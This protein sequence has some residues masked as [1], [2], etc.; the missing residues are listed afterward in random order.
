MSISPPPEV[1][2]EVLGN[3]TRRKPHTR[4]S[5]RREASASGVA[6]FDSMGMRIKK[7]ISQTQNSALPN[8][9]LKSIEL[10]AGAGG[11]AL[12]VSQAGFA[13]QAVIEMDGDC[14]STMRANKNGSSSLTANWPVLKRNVCKLSY[15]PFGTDLD[16]LAG[17][18]PCQP[19]SQGGKGGGHR[20]TRNMFPQAVRA[21]RELRPKTFVFENVN[22]L[23]RWAFTQYV[24][25]L[26]LC[27]AYPDLLQSSKET[28]LG[29]H[30]RLERHHTSG[31]SESYRIVIRS[32]NAANYGVPQSRERVIIVG[33]RSDLG[34]D[35]QFPTPSHS[36]AQLLGDQWIT[37]TYWD[38]HAIPKKNRPLVPRELRDTIQR[39]RDYDSPGEPWQ[40][41][42]DAIGDLS[43]PMETSRDQAAV[44]NHLHIPGAKR[45]AG[46]TG[47][48]FDWPAKALKAGDH[49]VPGGENMLAHAN[50]RVRYFTVRECARLQTFPDAY[51]F[52]G[53]WRST[54]RQLGNAVPVR[55][56]RIVASS[57]ERALMAKHSRR[58]SPRNG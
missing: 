47:S 4:H 34:L 32:V 2:A 25:Y 23:L 43:N 55:L 7:N 11:M 9:S 30:R 45:Y 48:R 1:Q 26:R 6:S 19:F 50:G 14:C 52:E 27:F 16:L 49:G 41:V 21:V 18:P 5:N 44:A 8:Q 35:W 58:N 24:D 57:L 3:E 40:T 17:G 28:W 51:L 22:G 42:R 39:L 31:A 33:V 13:H 15:S 20:D 36:E 12:G 46:H 38:K 56:A 53:G 37:G 29:H 54:T 10:F